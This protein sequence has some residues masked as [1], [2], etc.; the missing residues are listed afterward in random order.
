MK[1][2]VSKLLFT[3]NFSFSSP[4]TDNRSCCSCAVSPANSPNAPF[5]VCSQ[6]SIHAPDISAPLSCPAPAQVCLS[7]PCL[8]QWC[9]DHCPSLT[10]PRCACLIPVFYNDPWTS[11]E[12]SPPALPLTPHPAAPTWMLR[13]PLAF[14]GTVQANLYPHPAQEWLHSWAWCS[15]LWAR[16]PCS[17]CALAVAQVHLPKINLTHHQPCLFS[18]KTFCG[19]LSVL[20]WLLCSFKNSQLF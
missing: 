9:L 7:L 5:S 6:S 11:A 2:E 18:A 15:W 3:G 4:I 20:S 1:L 16:P 13:H 17:C 19:A 10:L 14:S 12:A 8:L